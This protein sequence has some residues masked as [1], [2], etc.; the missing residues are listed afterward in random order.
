MKK[1][2]LINSVILTALLNATPAFAQSAD[3]TKVQSFLTNIIQIMVTLAGLVSVAFFVWGG[4]RYM[5]SSGNPEAL[6]GAK[7]TVLYSGVGLAIALGAYVLM[8]II[9]Q[10]ATSAFGGAH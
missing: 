7:K 10:V 5:T 2:L 6:D 3:V 8:N 1:A 4:F 9:T